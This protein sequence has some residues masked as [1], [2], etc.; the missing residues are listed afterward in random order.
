[1][2]QYPKVKDYGINLVE[3][4]FIGK[5]PLRLPTKVITGAVSDLN[6]LCED[7]VNKFYIYDIFEELA[8]FLSKEIVFNNNYNFFLIASLKLFSLKI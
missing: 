7:G 1:M 2:L 5:H 8:I 3:I 6:A 4:K